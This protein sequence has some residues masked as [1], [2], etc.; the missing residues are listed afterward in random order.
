MDISSND[1]AR[2]LIQ[3]IDASPTPFHVVREVKRRLDEAGFH[4]LK[5]S[6]RW[7]L[8]EK[9]Y[10]VI[11]GGTSLIA[12]I[13]GSETLPCFTGFKI[14][15]AHT[16]SPTLK[17]KPNY[18]YDQAGYLQLGVEPYG[19]GVWRT[20]LDRDL[21]IAGRV[22]VRTRDGKISSHLVEMKDCIVSVP[23]QAIHLDRTVNE[24]GAINNQS[25][26]PVI[27]ALEGIKNSD[28][29]N[30]AIL[31]SCSLF[32]SEI[33]SST[34]SLCSTESG[35]ITGLNRE[36]IRSGQLDDLA[37]C[38]QAIMA[39]I[40]REN[41]P[42]TCIVSLLDHEEVG[43]NTS[44]GAGG[45]FLMNVLERIVET[46]TGTVRKNDFQRMIAKSFYISADMAHSVHPNHI[47]KH[48]PRHL[49]T[50]GGGP[51]VKR[52][53]DQHYATDDITAAIFVNLCDIAGVKYQM[54]VSRSDARC[55]S[56]IGPITASKLGISVVD[57]GNPMFAMHSIRE[58]CGVE[59]HLA[60]EKVFETFFAREQEEVIEE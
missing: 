53:A 4:E 49:I 36:F 39:L 50:I 41:T 27:V 1:F 45:S 5:E 12:F 59:D 56:T 14:I 33:L 32:G 34:L 28:L 23:G 60:M 19:G 42:T 51:V 38:H 57:V 13:T 46:A 43:S 26:L 35:I 44:Q 16:D 37:S 30:R 58:Q 54:F 48:D 11:R 21:Y 2:D 29:F 31:D 24:G 47:S 9:R 18:L 40:S 25:D 6:E 10:Y 17:L 15:G 7:F 8:K 52:N 3:F 22:V 20:L 55:G